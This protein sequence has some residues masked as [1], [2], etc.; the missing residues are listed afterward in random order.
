LKAA[1]WLMLLAGLATGFAGPDARA[2]DKPLWELGV[3]LGALSLPHYLGSDQQHTYALPLPYFVYRGKILKADREGTRAVLFESDRIDFDVSGSVMPPTR[4]EDNDARRGMADL[5]PTFELGPNLNLTL[6]RG[7]AWKFDLRV[8]VHGVATLESNPRFVGWNAT[9]RLNL[10][11]ANVGGSGWNVGLVGAVSFAT[12]DVHGRIYDVD[13]ADAL[14]DRPTYRA[15]GGYS[16]A[17]LRVSLSRR[18]ESVWAG[19][20][21]R[22]D[23]IDGARYEASPLVRQ[24]GNVFVGFAASWVFATSATMVD[25]PDLP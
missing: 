14:P 2:A 12:R 21:V 11:V 7:P 6:A 1:S 8:P 20:Y 9:P 4:S 17:H 25:V 3:G 18:F 24:R 15:R 16:G 13:P 19:V 5:K 23:R 10:D 22:G